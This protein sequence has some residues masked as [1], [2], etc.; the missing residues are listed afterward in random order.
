M[1]ENYR[2]NV[3]LSRDEFAA[4]SKAAQRDLRPIRDHARYLLRGLLAD[5]PDLPSRQ[6]KNEGS[7]AR[8]DNRGAT[9]L[10]TQS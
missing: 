1:Q 6:V 4:L 5:P 2:V 3:P 10:G 8:L 7:A 9:P